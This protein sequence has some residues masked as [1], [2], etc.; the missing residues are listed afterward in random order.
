MHWISIGLVVLVALAIIVIGAQ[1]VTI[2]RMVA[3]SFGLAP[4]EEGRNVAWWLRLKGVRDIGSGVA[5]LA[6]LAWAGPRAV[7]IVV[8]ALTTIPVGD[9]LTILASKGS[10]AKAF[11][12]HGL[13]AV[14]MLVASIPLILGA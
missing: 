9:M 13:T 3:R 8:L 7:G 4:P 14:L 5:V 6:C 2:P 12:I 11:G 10:A 1:Y